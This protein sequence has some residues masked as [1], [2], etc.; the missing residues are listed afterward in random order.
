MA[1]PRGQKDNYSALGVVCDVMG[2]CILSLLGV[3]IVTGLVLVPAWADLMLARH[4]RDCIRAEIAET[5]KLIAANDRLISALPQ[6][7]VLNERL[8]MSYL[9]ELPENE[10]V[11]LDAGNPPSDPPGVV[12]PTK[13]PRPDPPSPRLIQL[14]DK[15]S[16]RPTRLGLFAMATGLFIVAFCLFP[17]AWARG[18]STK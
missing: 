13:S 18:R 16:H 15:L 11:V 6:D 2:F 12:R 9:R 5:E 1:P 7:R 3:G 10:V 17:P 4:R 8:A 14:A